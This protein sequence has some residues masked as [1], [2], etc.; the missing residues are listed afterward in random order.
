[1]YYSLLFGGY[2]LTSGIHSYIRYRRVMEKNED[3][4]GNKIIQLP[5][6]SKGIVLNGYSKIINM[7]FYVEAPNTGI[8]VPIGGGEISESAE[9]VY[10]K[11]NDNFINYRIIDDTGEIKFIN[12]SDRLNEILE[13]YKIE[14][15]AFKMSLPLQ[16]VEYKWIN[17][18]KAL[19]GEISMNKSQLVFNYAMKKRYP[20]TFVALIIGSIWAFI[21][22]DDFKRERR[23]RR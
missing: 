8:N 11:V 18:P 2:V 22:Y 12:K 20:L 17:G 1:M 3:T 7:P 6:N 5:D 9:Q 10:S 13:K 4:N 19:N 15:T 16:S 14:D 21:D 23:F